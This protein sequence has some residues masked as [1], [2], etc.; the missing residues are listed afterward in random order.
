MGLENINT[1]EDLTQ[2]V[3]N[4]FQYYPTHESC[5]IERRIIRRLLVEINHFGGRNVGKKKMRCSKQ[6]RAIVLR[7]TDPWGGNGC[8]CYLSNLSY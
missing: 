5:R 6:G 3:N 4:L 2:M 7:S 8:R 1:K